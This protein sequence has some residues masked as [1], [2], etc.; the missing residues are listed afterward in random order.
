MLQPER[1]VMVRI[2]MENQV[3]NLQKKQH[4]RLCAAVGA[5]AGV[6]SAIYRDV[7]ASAGWLAALGLC[8]ILSAVA[9]LAASF[10]VGVF[11]KPS[12]GST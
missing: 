9:A 1:A 10:V 4:L 11:V 2:A 5:A 8:A 3:M 6:G 7:E 12:D